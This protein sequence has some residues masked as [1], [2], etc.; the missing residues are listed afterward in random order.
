MRDAS[1]LESDI[2]NLWTVKELIDV[3]I[4]RY[5]DHPD[6]LTEDQVI[7]GLLAISNA[8]ELHWERLFDTY[9][10]VWELDEYAPEEAKA[11]REKLLKKIKKAKKIDM[12][13][14]C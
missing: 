7:N 3:L 14:R 2:H 10:Q 13:G 5:G 11:Y 12:D 1:R 4:W 6:P 8:F 9:K